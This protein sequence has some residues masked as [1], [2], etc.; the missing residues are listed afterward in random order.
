[1]SVKTE[2]QNPIDR[3]ME[4]A[5]RALVDTSYFEA[6]RLAKDALA[7]AHAASDFE[8]MARII[9]PLQEARR[10]KRQL[11]VDAGNAGAVMVFTDPRFLRDAAA[12]LPAGCYLL[13]PPLLGVDARNL[14][15]EF[16]HRN[17]PAL[18]LC[19]E[20][21]TKDLKWPVVSVGRV[22]LRTRIAPHIELAREEKSVSKD[23]Y[24][25]EP[26]PPIS[27][28]ESAAEAIG[29]AAIL[30]IKPEDPAAWRVDDLMN[31]LDAHPDHEKLHQRLEENCRQAIAEDLPEN[32]RHRPVD[33]NPYSF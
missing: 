21:L 20:P 31:Y 1:M 33:D 7:K 9:L 18:V 3:L 14:R 15:E 6:E 24:S 4:R 16:T 13:Q 10:Q 19:R 25:G 26:P 5:S 28:F 29:D 12:Q 30:K 27:W 23:S 17:I 22:S 32:M 8:R 2:G 11:A